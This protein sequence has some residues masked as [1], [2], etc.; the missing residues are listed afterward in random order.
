MD[1]IK[2]LPP[3]IKNKIFQYWGEHP[4]ATIFKKHIKI[5][6]FHVDTPRE[7]FSFKII[8]IKRNR[9]CI[10]GFNRINEDIIASNIYELK[11]I[12]NKLLFNTWHQYARFV[13]HGSL[14]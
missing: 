10:V 14:Y 4:L 7:C 1:I 8:D 3:E 2:L 9:D 6:Y 13:M 12:A 11:I 5:L